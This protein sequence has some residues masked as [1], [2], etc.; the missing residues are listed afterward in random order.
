MLV[1]TSD[2]TALASIAAAP[3]GAG[4]WPHRHTTLLPTTYGCSARTVFAIIE[5][6]LL[7]YVTRIVPWSRSTLVTYWPDVSV[8]SAGKPASRRSAG[9]AR[10]RSYVSAT[11]AF[12]AAARFSPSV[13]C[14]RIE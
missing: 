9:A 13:T 14:A 12:G 8:G 10:V 3:G 6:A 5:L 2:L 1:R 4:A 7:P 11:A